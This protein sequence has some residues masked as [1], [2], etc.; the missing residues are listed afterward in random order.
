MTPT[1][2]NRDMTARAAHTR[3][4]LANFGDGFLEQIVTRGTAL[5]APQC[6]W[7]QNR[8]RH[9]THREALLSPAYRNPIPARDIR[10]GDVISEGCGMRALVRHTYRMPDSGRVVLGISYLSVVTGTP[11]T[12][13]VQHPVLAG[14]DTSLHLVT[15]DPA[16]VAPYAVPL[17]EVTR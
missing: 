3:R 1:T 9:E 5:R 6:A 4:A 16:D 13:T 8:R 15:R 17:P 14:T 2:D 11:D 12:H 10:E 7:E